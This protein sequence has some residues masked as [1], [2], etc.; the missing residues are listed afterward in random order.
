MIIN[1]INRI[2]LIKGLG[3]PGQTT[4]VKFS[5]K[6]IDL[7]RELFA[8]NLLR[9]SEVK[10]PHTLDQSKLPASYRFYDPILYLARERIQEF[11][12]EFSAF[13]RNIKTSSSQVMAGNVLSRSKS[14]NISIDEKLNAEEGDK[15]NFQ[16]SAKCYQ[17]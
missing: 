15:F 12:K 7:E 10:I 1:S 6:I 11:R 16:E 5:M 2:K 17:T 13:D 14:Q 3:F 4:Y 9:G 8:M